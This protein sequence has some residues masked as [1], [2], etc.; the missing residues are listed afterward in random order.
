VKSISKNIA[1][2][3]I[4]LL[5]TGAGTSAQAQP[6]TADVPYTLS[7]TVGETNL[8]FA[9]PEK[10]CFLDRTAVAQNSVYLMLSGAVEKNQD[11]MV[12]A[13]FMPC[14]NVS[15]LDTPDGQT[16]LGFIAWNA[17]AGDSTRLN[18]QDYLDMREASFP[19]YAKS[20]NLGTASDKAVHRT[21]YDVA[22]AL[23]DEEG[24]RKSI[25]VIAT[26]TLRHVPV[27]ITVRYAN[28]E[29]VS[30]FQQAYAEMDKIIEEQI[31][32]NE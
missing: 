26:T 5:I 13:V 7:L 1:A 24:G 3:G 21:P 2:L 22:L 10:M 12:L 15:A 18:R 16:D 23:T 27:E 8:Q 29:K 28:N 6:K 30:N 11:E 19:Q 31:K 32:L 25:V 14:D 17:Q 4:T 9:P 20:R